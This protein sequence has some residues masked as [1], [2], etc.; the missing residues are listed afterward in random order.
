MGRKPS[1]FT[2]VHA[3]RTRDLERLSSSYH[4]LEYIFSDDDS[5]EMLTNFIG[6]V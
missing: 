5:F 6:Q 3:Y 4:M 1:R 2:V